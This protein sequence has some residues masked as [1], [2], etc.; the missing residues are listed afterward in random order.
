M[1]GAVVARDPT[2]EQVREAVQHLPGGKDSF[3]ILDAGGDGLTYVQA[4]GSPQEGFHL[5]Y[6]EGSSEQHFEC[7]QN[8]LPAEPVISVLLAF[9][10][11]E[12]GWRAG[13]PWRRIDL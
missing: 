8:P 13:V 7:T 9:L 4:A 10:S 6:Q 1:S 12:Q 11:G 5:E 2:P 3:V